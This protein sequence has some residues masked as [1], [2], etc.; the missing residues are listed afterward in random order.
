MR[1]QKKLLVAFCLFVFLS[2]LN[3]KAH[4]ARLLYVSSPGAETRQERQLKDSCD[5][6]GLEFSKIIIQTPED[7]KKIAGLLREAQTVILAVDARSLHRLSRAEIARQIAVPK[8]GGGKTALIIIGINSDTRSDDLSLWSDGK[9]KST[10]PIEPGVTIGSVEYT[11]LPDLNQALSNQK[12]TVA[13][14]KL[15]YFQHDPALQPG[16]AIG[17]KTKESDRLLPIM[18]RSKIGRNDIFFITE[19]QFMETDSSAQDKKEDTLSTILPV[20]VPIKYACGTYCWHAA[21]VYANFSIDDPFL[22]EPYGNLSYSG[23]LREMEKSRFHTTIAFIPWNYNRSENDAV[24]IVKNNPDKYSISMHGCDHGLQEFQGTENEENENK[25]VLAL[26]RMEAFKNFTGIEYDKVMIMPRNPGPAEMMRLLKKYNFLGTA[27]WRNIPSDMNPDTKSIHRLREA[28]FNVGGFPSLKRYSPELSDFE[29]AKTIYFGSPLLFQAHQIEFR[30]GMNWFNRTAEK[31]NKICPKVR[32]VSLGRVFQNLYLKK[33]IDEQD[34]DVK[35]HSN[36]ITIENNEIRNAVYHIRK[37]DD[38]SIPIRRVLIQGRE[39]TF[40][41]SGDELILSVTI[42][43]REIREIVV[44]YEND[45]MID[46]IVL[47]RIDIDSRIF[48]WLAE[49]RDREFSRTGIGRQ[50]SGILYPRGNTREYTIFAIILLFSVLLLVCIW[51][52]KRPHKTK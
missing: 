47:S 17:F 50:L 21:G 36:N 39:H 33:K 40:E 35:M 7:G 34:W 41:K 12:M 24:E 5:F 42:P 38:F 13:V 23:L 48:R 14:D 27:N 22:V 29:I 8:Q 28:V 10:S 44:E 2:A 46:G 20:F 30:S 25:I 9:I 11:D 43:P 3:G 45:P 26:A 49:F 37:D 19:Y 16:I 18:M 32:W 1:S 4:A 51:I 6:Y 31:V 15:Y 52:R